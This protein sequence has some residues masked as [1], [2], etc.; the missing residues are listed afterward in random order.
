LQAMPKVLVVDDNPDLCHLLVR[1]LQMF[2]HDATCVTD[3]ASA[4]DVAWADPPAVVFLDVTMPGLD[5]FDVLQ[6]LRSDDRT[7]A[8]PVVM[9]SAI[10]D[11]KSMR[12]AMALGAQD[13]VVKGA[14]DLDGLREVVWKWA[15]KAVE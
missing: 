1:V 10:A 15:G 13:Y 8:V 12:R 4:L 9:Y 14:A 6:A 11:P 3:G 5:G 7:R 2:G